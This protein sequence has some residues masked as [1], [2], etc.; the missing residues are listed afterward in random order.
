MSNR[1]QVQFIGFDCLN[2]THCRHSFGQEK[3]SNPFLA[4]K[5]GTVLSQ[6]LRASDT[7]SFVIFTAHPVS[8]FTVLA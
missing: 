3:V 8:L 4:E 7:I 5:N 2:L 6:S 1:G